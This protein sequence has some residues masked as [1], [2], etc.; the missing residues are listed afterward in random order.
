MSSLFPPS[1]FARLT[2]GRVKS[3]LSHDGKLLLNLFYIPHVSE[4]ILLLLIVVIIIVIITV[5]VV[6]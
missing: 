2:K 6:V 5:F 1:L 3:F 4:V